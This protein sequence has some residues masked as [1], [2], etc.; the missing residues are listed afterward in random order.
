MELPE[1]AD[2]GGPG[3]SVFLPGAYLFPG[4]FIFSQITF[5]KIKLF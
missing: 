3:E 2:I 5:Q 4:V 1:G